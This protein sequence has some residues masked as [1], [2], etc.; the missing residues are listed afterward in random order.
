MPEGLQECLLTIRRATMALAVYAAFCI[1]TLGQTDRHIFEKNLEVKIPLVDV[2]VEFSGFL[3]LG[4]I[5]LLVVWVYLQ[6]HLQRVFNGDFSNCPPEPRVLGTF[7]HPIPATLAWMAQYAAVPV[8]LTLFAFRAGYLKNW[9]QF[10]FYLLAGFGGLSCVLLAT[11][12]RWPD[13]PKDRP[14][15]V[16]GFS[17]R[18]PR[19][20]SLMV[21]LALLPAV[22]SVG[23][24]LGMDQANLAGAALRQRD[25]SGYHLVGANLQEADLSGAMLNGSNL[26]R[27]N[28]R[29]ANLNQAHLQE[30]QL[31]R[32]DATGG[33]LAGADLQGANLTEATLISA[34]LEGAVLFAAKLVRASL[35]RATLAGANLI[36][37]DLSGARLNHADLTR[38]NL[39]QADLTG[40]KFDG[41]N[42]SGALFAQGNSPP[43]PGWIIGR[44]NRLQKTE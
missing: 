10:Y 43:P 24:A 3:I 42:L 37:A 8:V 30:A 4:P 29:G 33:N 32:A 11:Y 35:A 6:I 36:R 12:R 31:A 18:W 13:P 26:M 40:A 41:A 38:A 5:G 39:T 16:R 7:S 15:L 9:G 22:I 2:P 20:A 19:R 1:V 17:T 23:I 25:L 34:N 28:L 44:D 21:D 14:W 27:A